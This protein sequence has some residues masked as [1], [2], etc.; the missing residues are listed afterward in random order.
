MKRI[1][2]EETYIGY[3]VVALFFLIGLCLSLP[4][5]IRSLSCRETVIAKIV[6]VDE[7][8]V[9]DIDTKFDYVVRLP[10]VVYQVDDVKYENEYGTHNNIDKYQIGQSVKIRYKKSDPSCFV[11]DEHFG[12]DYPVFLGF[13][14]MLFSV[15]MVYKIRKL[16]K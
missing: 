2:K 10:K 8:I 7:D 4:G 3:A 9:R 6:D 13:F 12:L 11:I 5:T 1:S 14:I 15:G 16:S